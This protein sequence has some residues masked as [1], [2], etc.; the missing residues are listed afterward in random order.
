M[1]INRF[2]AY[3]GPDIDSRFGVLSN[4]GGQRHRQQQEVPKEVSHKPAMNNL[5]AVRA[6]LSTQF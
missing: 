3:R 5:E 6:G 4:L 2:S 1:K